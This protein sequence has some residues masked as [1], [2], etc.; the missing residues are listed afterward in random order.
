M[1]IEKLKERKAQLEKER[2]DFVRQVQS[3]IDRYVG[4]IAML[5]EII[6]IEGAHPKAVPPVK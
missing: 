6:A 2:D 1:T 3:Q 4:A 5:D